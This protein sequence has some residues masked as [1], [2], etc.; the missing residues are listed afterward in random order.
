MS[1]VTKKFLWSNAPTQSRWSEIRRFYVPYDCHKQLILTHEKKFSI[2]LCQNE[3]CEAL[4]EVG[5]NALDNKCYRISYRYRE[6]EELTHTKSFLKPLYDSCWINET[7]V[8]K[9]SKLKP[10]HVSI[11]KFMCVSLKGIPGITGEDKM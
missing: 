3:K 7:A 5:K 1:F 10:D 2:L 4:H 6:N 11:E 8:T 9:I